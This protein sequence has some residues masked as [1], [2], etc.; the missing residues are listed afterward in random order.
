[1]LNALCE[2]GL[3]VAFQRMKS[4]KFLVDDAAEPDGSDGAVHAVTFAS[5]GV[6][7]K[8]SPAL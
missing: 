4:D 3:R 6:G 2:R 5:V 7:R 8:K 1:L